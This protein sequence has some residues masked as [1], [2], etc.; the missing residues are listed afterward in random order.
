[1]VGRFTRAALNGENKPRPAGIA[2]AAWR[3]FPMSVSNRRKGILGNLQ[4]A[5]ISLESASVRAGLNSMHRA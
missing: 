3:N 5:V 1:M 2:I 4:T